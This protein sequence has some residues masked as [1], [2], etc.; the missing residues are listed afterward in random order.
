MYIHICIYITYVYIYMFTYIYI[1]YGFVTYDWYMMVRKYS[2]FSTVTKTTPAG[3]R[4]D[5]HKPRLEANGASE[6]SWFAGKFH[7]LSGKSPIGCWFI[8]SQSTVCLLQCWIRTCE[9]GHLS[10]HPTVFFH[11]RS[12]ETRWFHWTSTENHQLKPWYLKYNH[13]LYSYL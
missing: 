2:N 8:W 11:N 6:V 3:H 4:Q 1:Y 12:G 9:R 10:A 13:K 7:R 5:P